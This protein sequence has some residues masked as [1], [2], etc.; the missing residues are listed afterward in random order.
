[1]KEAETN[2]M[3]AI[4]S[5]PLPKQKNSLPNLPLSLCAA[6]I[7]AFTCDGVKLMQ[8]RSYDPFLLKQ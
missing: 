3:Y 6:L 7:R 5:L 1:M 2:L 4:S 8:I